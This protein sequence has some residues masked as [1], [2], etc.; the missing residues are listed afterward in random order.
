MAHVPQQAL[1]AAL[2]WKT[3][4]A[5]AQ[6][7]AKESQPTALGHPPRGSPEMSHRDGALTVLAGGEGSGT[8][9]GTGGG[10]LTWTLHFHLLVQ[11][12]PLLLSG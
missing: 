4:G 10:L 2:A 6:A 3:D 11:P 7:G 12:W 9:S 1:Q 5:Q 8:D